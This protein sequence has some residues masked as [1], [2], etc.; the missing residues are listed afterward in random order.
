V[1]PFDLRAITASR[2]SS[3]DGRVE[4]VDEVRD[5]LGG[6]RLP[7]RSGGRRQFARSWRQVVDRQ[8][9]AGTRW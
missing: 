9:A 2:G 3:C 1:H 7:A 4:V 6:G 8:P 5:Q